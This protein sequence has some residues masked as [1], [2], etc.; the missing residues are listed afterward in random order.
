M[1]VVGWWMHW[2]VHGMRDLLVDGEFDLFV[3]DMGSVDG[4]LDFIWNGFLDDVRNLLDDLGW[5]KKFLWL[6]KNVNIVGH[7]WFWLD[8]VVPT[9]DSCGQGL[10]QLG[11]SK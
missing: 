4:D 10:N 11:Q 9:L 6:E 8:E 7:G 2:D 3:N 5:W 1:A